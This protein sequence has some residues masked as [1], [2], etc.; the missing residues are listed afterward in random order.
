MMDIFV[1]AMMN[2]NGTSEMWEDAEAH[3]NRND[4]AM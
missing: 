2:K 1:C 4:A 3:N